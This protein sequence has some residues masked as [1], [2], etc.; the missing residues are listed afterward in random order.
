M[1]PC[2]DVTLQDYNGVAMILA[3][4]PGPDGVADDASIRCVFTVS[5][6]VRGLDRHILSVAQFVS[7]L[8]PGPLF[9]RPSCCSPGWLVSG[10][11]LSRPKFLPLGTPGAQKPVTADGCRALGIHP[12]SIQWLRRGGGDELG[13]LGVAS[14][15][16]RDEYQRPEESPPPH[17]SCLRN[18]R[19]W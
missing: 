16:R 17:P 8:A 12:L 15:I 4:P 18:G 9:A 10:I 2:R 6:E 1:G 5:R 19:G 3:D 13:S 7:L 11:Q 14:P